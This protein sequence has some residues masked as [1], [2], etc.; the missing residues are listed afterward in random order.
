MPYTVCVR[1]FVPKLKNSALSAISTGQQ[2]GARQFDHRADQIGDRDP[3]LLH[4][5]AGNPIDHRLQ[6]VEFA[7]RRDQRHH[8]LGLDRLAAS[9]ASPSAAASKIATACVS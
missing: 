7:L 5:L 9:P 6:D 3:G 4:H 1:S 2:R 8:D